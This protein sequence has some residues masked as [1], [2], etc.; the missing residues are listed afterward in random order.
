MPIIIAGANGL[1]GRA[2][3]QNFSQYDNVLGIDIKKGN[4]DNK[5]IK[6]EIADLTE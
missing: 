3:F 5:N 6:W 1:I 2:L 4:F